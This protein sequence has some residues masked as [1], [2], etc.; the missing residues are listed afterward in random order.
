MWLSYRSVIGEFKLMKA[1]LKMK[2][3]NYK[4]TNLQNHNYLVKDVD[5]TFKQLFQIRKVLD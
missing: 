2:L 1:E 5:K 3:L 4:N